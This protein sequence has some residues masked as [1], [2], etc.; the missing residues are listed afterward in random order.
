MERLREA[1]LEPFRVGDVETTIS[2]SIGAAEYPL[3]GRDAQ[4]LVERA[5]GMMRAVK[6]SRR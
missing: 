6:R 2:V 5:N 3:D 4:T 1:L